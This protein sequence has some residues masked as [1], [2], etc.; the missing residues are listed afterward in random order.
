MNA[1]HMLNSSGFLYILS[2]SSIYFL[3]KVLKVL[4]FI[5]F[6]VEEVLLMTLILYLIVIFKD[7]INM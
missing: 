4:Y 3:H 5:Y 6:N 7:T 2:P 1:L